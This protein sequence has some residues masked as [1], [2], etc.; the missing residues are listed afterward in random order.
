MLVF[1]RVRLN[2]IGWPLCRSLCWSP[3]MPLSHCVF[4]FSYSK[5]FLPDP[6]PHI[7]HIG[8]CLYYYYKHTIGSNQLLYPFIIRTRL[9]ESK[10]RCP[11]SRRGELSNRPCREMTSTVLTLNSDHTKTR[12][13]SIH[14]I[15]YCGQGI[16][17]DGERSQAPIS[18]FAAC[19][20]DMLAGC[21]R[22][23]RC[24]SPITW[25]QSL[26][27]HRPTCNGEH[28]LCWQSFWSIFRDELHPSQGRRWRWKWLW[29]DTTV[30]P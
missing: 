25:A 23:F 22:I 9:Q 14:G 29:M 2:F 30:H 11:G 3:G 4:P 7:H 27:H 13:T 12:Y 16:W 18:R 24:H 26:G 6:S 17:L 21:G 20:R 8:R 5:G 19:V 15:Q 10:K 28:Q 1:R